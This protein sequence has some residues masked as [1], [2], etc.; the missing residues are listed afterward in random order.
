MVAE[1]V[2]VYMEAPDRQRLDAL[3]R[4]LGLTKSAVLRQALKSLEREIT[5]VAQHPVLRVIGLASDDTGPAVS[6]VVAREHDRY[7]ADLEDQR[8]ASRSRAKKRGA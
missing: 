8:A 6:Y 4:Q 1:P 2:Q 5:D 3:T 7:L